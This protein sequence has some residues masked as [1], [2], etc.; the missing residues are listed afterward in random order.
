[1]LLTPSHRTGR[2]GTWFDSRALLTQEASSTWQGRG[3]EV[4]LVSL[5]LTLS[6]PQD[7][8]NHILIRLKALWW[9]TR[10]ILSSQHGRLA[11]TAVAC[12]WQVNPSIVPERSVC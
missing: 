12:L 1:M 9:E 6:H 3:R 7:I 11:V 10:D 5:E 2:E 8:D 4:S